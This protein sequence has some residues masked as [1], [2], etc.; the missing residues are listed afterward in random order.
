MKC[1]KSIKKTDHYKL[2]EI[3]RVKEDDADAKVA[4]GG[5]KFIPK[6]EWKGELKTLVEKEKTNKQTK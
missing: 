6:S 4:S 5:W 3:R 2:G 1:I